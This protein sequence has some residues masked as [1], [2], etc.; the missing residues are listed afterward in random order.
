MNITL[1]KPTVADAE[2]LYAVIDANR[3]HLTN[4]V[5]AASATRLSTE[6]FLASVP[7]TEKLKVILLDG[8][9]VGMITL[10]KESY[11][12]WSIGYWL[13]H[14]VRRKGI[15][16]EAVKQMLVNVPKKDFVEAHIRKE[17]IASRK[18]LAA[19]GF[20]NH[21]VDI[22]HDGKEWLDV[23]VYKST[24]GLFERFFNK[25]R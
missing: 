9:I 24:H 7:A 20:M 8:R 11:R 16:T 14:D 21:F 18:V 4:L 12:T 3:E 2:E 13:A 1:R 17:N 10:R 25:F 22:S 19:N 15:M 5:W 23:W 6:K